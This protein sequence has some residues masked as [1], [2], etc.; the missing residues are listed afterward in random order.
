MNPSRRSKSRSP[1][2][3][4]EDLPESSSPNYSSTFPVSTSVPPLPPRKANKV[5]AAE[6][7]ALH[8]TPQNQKSM[9][10]PPSIPHRTTY[11]SVALGNRS[12]LSENQGRPAYSPGLEAPSLG[13]RDAN[14]FKGRLAAWTSAAQASGSSISRSESTNT[15]STSPSGSFG[16]FAGQ[17]RLPASAQRV[18]GNAGSAVQKG[19]AGFRAKGVGGSISSMSNLAAASRRSVDKAGRPA[20]INNSWGSTLS[21][22][23]SSKTDGRSSVDNAEGGSDGPIFE[24][25]VCK[26]RSQGRTG[27]LFGRDLVEAGQTWPVYDASELGED[28]DEWQ[29]RRK[30]C[31]PALV[32]RAVDYCK[33]IFGQ[34]S[35]QAYAVNS[36]AVGPEGRGNI[37]Y[38][39]TDESYHSTSERIRCWYVLSAT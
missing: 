34:V 11:A 27:R 22:G 4:T 7:A 35:F 6:S 13:P 36:G 28:V 5:N 14:S 31:L 32:V 18:L 23:G 8:E 29:K 15:L 12:R 26:R 9:P 3:S 2:S 20:D 16:G 38:Q 1:A 21:R 17:Q 30:R 25:G 24:E 19:W 33:S 39:R 37:P 10:P